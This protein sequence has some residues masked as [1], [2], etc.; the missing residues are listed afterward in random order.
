MFVDQ[1]LRRLRPVAEI[2]RWVRVRPG[3]KKQALLRIGLG[4]ISAFLFSCA[5]AGAGMESVRT[6]DGKLRGC[7]SS[8]NCVCSDS[9]GA[10]HFI[11]P[12]EIDRLQL[13]EQLLDKYLCPA[14]IFLMNSRDSGNELNTAGWSHAALVL[15]ESGRLDLL[16]LGFRASVGRDGA[17][18]FFFIAT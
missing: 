14:Q 1:T 18:Q 8:P 9:D 13:S 5:S 10:S 2:L 3:A 15:V 11:E 6:V 7:P 16:V 17:C 12:L 4:L